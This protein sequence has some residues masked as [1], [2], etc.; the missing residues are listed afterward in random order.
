MC[1]GGIVLCRAS[2]DT[3]DNDG[4]YLTVA[5]NYGGRQD[6]AAAVTK[7][8]ACQGVGLVSTPLRSLL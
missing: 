7:H 6:I 2:E 1:E 8:Q 3:R 4:L 5:L